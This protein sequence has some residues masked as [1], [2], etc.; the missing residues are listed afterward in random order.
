MPVTREYWFARRFPLG[1]RR[2]AY[3]PV[4]WKGW[5]ATALFVLALCGGGAAFV[6]FG[7]HDQMM[8]GVAA[9]SITA[10][11]A[12]SCFLLL[13]R[14]NGDPVRTVREYKEDQ[15]RA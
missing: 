2:Q 5:M 6:Y 1:D 13:V 15:K 4:H 3:A 12:M 10:F 11:V 7:M 9:F 14:A 8:E